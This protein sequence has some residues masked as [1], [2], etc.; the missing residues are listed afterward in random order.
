MTADSDLMQRAIEAAATVR[1]TTAP[2][3][4]VG[5]AL[6]TADGAV[7]VG[8]TEPPG[9]AH[10]EIVALRVAG[11]TALGATLATTL[12]PCAHQGRTGPCTRAIIDAGV[13]RVL[14][15][16]G[17]PDPQVA[18]AGVA[19]LRRAGIDV[20]TD[21]AAGDVEEQ[22]APYL[23]HR[24]TGRPFVVLK[25]AATVDGRTAAPDRTSQWITGEAARRD[26]H[27]LRAESQAIV[28]GAGTVREDDPAL[29]TR[30]VDGPDPRRIVLG[31]APAAAKVRPCD[32]WDGPLD[33]L[34]EDL[35]ADGVIQLMVEGGARVAASFH[36]QG[37]VD[38]YVIYLAPAM[39][40]GDDARPLF[41]GPGA[42][43]IGA[44]ARGRFT[45]A[46]LV[47]D[48]LR[49]VIDRLTSQP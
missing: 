32:E 18:G 42:P 20:V 43:T 25:L 5:A 31:T 8:A 35:G 19:E 11:P 12:E 27:R 9:G 41:A 14:V 21:V 30:L 46:G 13:S 2:N 28:V 4:W 49:V 39:F 48:D 26:A 23:H 16:V 22:L 10:A 24:R 38:R 34:L 15:G 36:R 44:L 3:P 47:G 33:Q 17:D 45:E 29:T 6:A 7:H 40:G 1:R 37:L